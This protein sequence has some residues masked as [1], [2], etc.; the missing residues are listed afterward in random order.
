MA[1]QELALVLD[2]LA[3]ISAYRFLHAV[4]VLHAGQAQSVSMPTHALWYIVPASPPA[5][6]QVHGR[7]SYPATFG[8]RAHSRNSSLTNPGP[9]N[10][11][12]LTCSQ[13]QS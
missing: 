9:A 11:T 10:S 1:G 6:T 8:G 13:T 7:Y 3:H 12:H 2:Q 5:E 4:P